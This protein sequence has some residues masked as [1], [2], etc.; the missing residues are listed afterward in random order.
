MEP[1]SRWQRFV[2]EPLVHFIVLGAVLFAVDQ[3][4]AARKD[5]PRVITMGPEVDAEIRTIFHGVKGRDPE[6]SEMKILRERWLDNEVL[7]RE[8]LAL[9]VDRGDTAIRERVIFK[10][11]NVVQANLAPPKVDDAT[12]RKW[13]EAHRA[14]YE[15]PVRIDFREAVLLGDRSPEAVEKFVKSLNAGVQD[16]AASGLRVYRGRPRDTIVTSFGAAFADAVERLPPGEWRALTASDGVH[17]VQ[18]EK[19]TP[20]TKVTFEEARSRVFDDWKD[21]TMQGLRTA[22][23]RDLAK[24]YTVRTVGGA[25]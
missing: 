14:D 16:D 9:G 7:Y 21:V 24:Q 11:L 22:A 12:L 4:I 18:L 15:L 6:P 17:V 3:G 5:D 13:F 1:S 8:G 20:G 23:V 2:R 25:Q 19:V 10:A